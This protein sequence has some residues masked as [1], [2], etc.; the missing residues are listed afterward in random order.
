MLVLLLPDF[1][2]MNDDDDDDDD[3]DDVFVINFWDKETKYGQKFV[4]LP[5]L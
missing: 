5:C 1:F 4:A 3:D 2:R